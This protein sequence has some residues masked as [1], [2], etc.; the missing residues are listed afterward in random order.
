MSQPGVAAVDRALTILDVFDEHDDALSL[1]ELARRTG[2]YKST[3]LRL[4]ASLEQAGYLRRLD[5]GH[6]RLGPTL[7][8]LGN[9]YQRSFR[10]EEY[11]TPVLRKLA[12][13][14]GESA[15]LYVR[16]GDKRICL[17][18]V[19]SPMHRVLHYVTVGTKLP[20]ETGAAGKVLLAFSEPED[21]NLADVRQDLLVI[22]SKNR[23]SETAAMACPVFS[24]HHPT[25]QGFV[26]ALSLA[27]PKTRF[28]PATMPD[29]R[30]AL[31]QAAAELSEALGGN[32]QVLREKLGE[33]VR[34]REFE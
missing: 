26:G 25:P 27:G 34:R 3:L 33:K 22:S 9:L 28:T 2:L 18:R 16:E 14:T 21:P 1:A 24:A 7:L 30:S 8:K 31:L 29:M 15:S 17:F 10:L 12:E 19:N 4:A 6:F 20:L 5:N 23:K 32:G 13:T 11:V